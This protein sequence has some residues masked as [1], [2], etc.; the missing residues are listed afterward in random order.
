MEECQANEIKLTDKKEKLEADKIRLLTS[1]RGETQE[2]QE[3]KE[4]LQ[5]ELVELNKA[6]VTTKSQV[7]GFLT[8]IT[9]I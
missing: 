6:V 4:V 5:T 1:L 9:F 8:I 2:L 3:Q 7:T